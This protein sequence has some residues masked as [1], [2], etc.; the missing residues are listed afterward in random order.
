MHQTLA[1][2]DVK[3]SGSKCLVT[4]TLGMFWDRCG[5]LDGQNFER[6]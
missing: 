6:K 5:R 3:A 4:F 2:E 1:I